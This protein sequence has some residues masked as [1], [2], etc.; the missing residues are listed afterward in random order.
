MLVVVLYLGWPVVWADEPTGIRFFA[1]PWQQVLAEARRQNKPVF[2]DFYTD[3][4]PPCRRMTREAFPN[5]LVGAAFNPRFI[6]YQLNAELGEGVALAQQYGVR[7]YPTALYLTPGG[8]LVHRAVGYGGVKAM[9]EQADLV[10]RLP[11]MRRAIKR[12]RHLVMDEA[13]PALPDTGRLGN[14]A[15]AGHHR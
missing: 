2:V 11:D 12:G 4:C 8:Q 9:I 1:G 3:W 5:P 10:L 7:S 14:P 15:P 13:A 6:N